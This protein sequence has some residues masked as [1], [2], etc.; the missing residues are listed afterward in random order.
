[1]FDV[2]LVNEKF[3]KFILLIKY[4]QP[5]HLPEFLLVKSRADITKSK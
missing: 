2:D 3:I 1:M 5:F 4:M